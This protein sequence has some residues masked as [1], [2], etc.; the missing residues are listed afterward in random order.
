MSDQILKAT[1]SSLGIQTYFGR[2]YN[3]MGGGLLMSALMA[4]LSVREPLFNLFYKVND[5]QLSM[6]VLGW[7]AIFA[8]L[9]VIFFIGNATSKL[10]I[11]QAKLW[12]WLFSA[13]MGISLG[14]LLFIYSGAAMFQAFLVTAGMFF[15][16]SLFGV[17]TSRDLSG[18]G[19]FL[20]MGLIG[21]ILASLVNIFVGS[22]QFNFILNILSVVIFVGLTAYDTNKLKAA[23]NPADSDEIVQA[24]SIQ[25]ALA[26]YL[27]FINLFRLML[28]FLNNRR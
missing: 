13:L 20:I 22:G 9:L 5:G 18:L 7:I 12:F 15:A 26:L 24:K 23:Y 3:Y 1:R 11:Q 8:P 21:V 28:Y 25:G 10:N 19:R 2:I 6:S 4:W 16:L 17:K 27:D 14:S